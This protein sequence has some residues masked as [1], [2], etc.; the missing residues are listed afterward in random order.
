M[1][2]NATSCGTSISQ[3]PPT[4]SPFGEVSAES[5]PPK[6]IPRSSRSW[7]LVKRPSLV[8]CSPCCLMLRLREYT[9]PKRAPVFSTRSE[10][11]T[12]ELQSRGHLVCRLLLE[13]K[14]LKPIEYI[15]IPIYNVTIATMS[16]KVALVVRIRK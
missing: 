15:T 5:D 12:S 13:K 1:F 9:I 7:Y 2:C 6:E 8:R 11:H 10:E 3:H 4:P 16:I 14:K